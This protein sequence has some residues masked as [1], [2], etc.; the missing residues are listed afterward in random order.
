MEKHTRLLVE[1]ILIRPDGFDWT[2]QGLGIMRIYLS[3]AVRLHIWDTSLRVP[4]VSAL[5]T[6]PWDLWSTVV[7]GRYRQY[8]YV[9]TSKLQY[10]V[11]NSEKFR[12]CEI[13]CGEN[14]CVTTEPT[15]IELAEMP[16]EV[17]IEGQS[18]QQLVDE[19]HVSCPEDG[20]VTLIERTF[21]EDTEHARV[22]WRGTGGWVDAKPR[23]ATEREITD[24]TQ[25]A[26][27]AW[28]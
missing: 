11:S 6:H 28:F 24:V 7:A 10:Q 19:I 17:L 2:V 25:R 20:T 8:R 18:Y 14:A 5:H 9:E 26:L 27:R 4:G 16:I 15:E 1:N 21:K 12:V 3:K 13:K 23:P 22:F